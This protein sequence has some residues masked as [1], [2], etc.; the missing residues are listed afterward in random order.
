MTDREPADA[1]AEP[2]PTDAA[3]GAG[4]A[5]EEPG[6]AP[7]R[8]DGAEPRRRSKKRGKRRDAEAASPPPEGVPARPRDPAL[9]RVQQAFERGDYAL[10]RAEAGRLAREAE[11]ADV[12]RAARELLRRIDPDPLAV[13][14]LLAA[15]ALLAF[16]SLWYWSHAH[17]AP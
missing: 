1:A 9:E 13:I 3:R 12:R 8:A 5:G 15:V 4:R 6:V 10:V 17:A 11:R 2:G 7:D 16:L 14:L